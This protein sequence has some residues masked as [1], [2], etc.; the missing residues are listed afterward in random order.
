MRIKSL[1]QGENILMLRFEPAT[2][3]S[4]IDILTTTPIVH[5]CTKYYL[6]VLISMPSTLYRIVRNIAKIDRPSFIA[7]LSRISQFSSVEMANQFCD[8]LR[9]VLDKNAPPSLQKVI[10]HN[11]SPWLESVRYELFIAKRERRQAERKWRNTKITIFKD[12]YRQAKHKV[13]KLVHTAKCK[14]YT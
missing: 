1:A 13:S 7:E 14:F 2:F 5:N 8:Y 9:T 3:V 6:D 11:S 10:A 12:L 4:K